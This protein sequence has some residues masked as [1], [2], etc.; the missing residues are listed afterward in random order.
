MSTDTLLTSLFRYKAWANRE[1]FA[2]LATLTDGAF[3]AARKDALLT[4]N[5][6]HIVDRIFRANLQRQVHGYTGTFPKE[7]PPVDM[8]AKSVAET[9][10]WYLDYLATLDATA[11]AEPIAFSFADG[12]PARMSR[13]EMLGHVITHGNFHRGE[14]SR[15]LA[16]APIELPHD[17]FTGY[18]HRAEPERRQTV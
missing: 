16:G 5:H 6:A 10:R 1:T 4:L 2:A 17:V 12:A 8:L 3:A 13:E 11:L 15:I 18:L 14:T 7:P 9:D